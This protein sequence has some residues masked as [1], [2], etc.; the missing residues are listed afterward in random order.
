MQRIRVRVVACAQ[1]I[2]R[3][4]CWSSMFEVDQTLLGRVGVPKGGLEGVS[5]ESSGACGTWI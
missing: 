2:A 4:G 1:R 3:E 5:I